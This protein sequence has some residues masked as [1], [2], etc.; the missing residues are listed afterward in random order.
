MPVSVLTHG[1][2]AV[3]TATTPVSVADLKKAFADTSDVRERHPGKARLLIVWNAELP[4]HLRGEITEMHERTA[5]VFERLVLQGPAMSQAA[6][7]ARVAM[8]RNSG[9]SIHSTHSLDE[10]IASIGEGLGEEVNAWLRK[11]RTTISSAPP[12][13]TSVPASPRDTPS[14]RGP[15]SS[16]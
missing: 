13:R 8:A 16:S 5:T 7:A 15:R 4:A 10:A 14:S 3:W 12:P 11:Q 2:I 9:P 6:L 1:N